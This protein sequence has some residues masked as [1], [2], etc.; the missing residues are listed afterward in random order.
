MD[1]D[2][3]AKREAMVET[4]II[5]RGLTDPRVLAAMREVPRERFVP[6]HAIAQAYDDHPIPLDDTPGAEAATI[7]QPYIVAEMVALGR[8]QTGMR[9][10]DV[11]SGSG[12]QAAVI[13]SMGARVWGIEIVPALVERSRRILEALGFGDRVQ[14]RQGD[15][16][17]G[18]PE[19]APFDAILVA[20]APRRVPEPLKAQLAIGARLVLPVGAWWQDLQVVE[21]TAAEDWR[22]TSVMPVSFV[23]LVGAG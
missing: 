11:G 3:A 12:Y 7:S 6:D 14:L 10:L 1:D 19:E 13:A 17:L 5:R 18:W 4:Q 16:G 22:I 21:R 15:G 23:P 20:A 8:I 2:W 9:V